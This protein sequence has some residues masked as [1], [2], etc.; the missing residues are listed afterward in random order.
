VNKIV[1]DM[2]AEYNQF[3]TMFKAIAIQIS[4]R[5]GDA[6]LSSVDIAVHATGRTHS[7]LEIEYVIG[8]YYDNEHVKANTLDAAVS[9]YLRRKGWIA[10]NKPIAIPY[11]E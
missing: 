9:E 7:D 3:E 5:L 8:S 4:N 1:E 2:M 6:D 11:V 10:I